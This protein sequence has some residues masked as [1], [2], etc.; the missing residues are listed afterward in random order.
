MPDAIGYPRKSRLFRIVAIVLAVFLTIYTGLS[1]FGAVAAMEIPRLPLMGSPASVGLAY[2]DVS[3]NS[4]TGNILLKGWYIPG[5]GE[6]AIIIVHGGFQN[7]V[8]DVVDTLDLAHDLA[9]DRLM[10][11]H[12][13]SGITR[14]ICDLGRANRH[15]GLLE[16]RKS[17]YPKLKQYL[18]AICEGGIV[19]SEKFTPAQ[20]M[21][22]KGSYGSHHATSPN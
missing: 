15:A 10:L 1:A 21:Q 13:P 9:P 8:D 12:N 5:D 18:W 19:E 17:L 3:F 6:R 11:F 2:Q 20:V 14:A 7:R 16:G 4:R 22:Q